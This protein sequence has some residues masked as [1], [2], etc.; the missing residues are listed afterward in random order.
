MTETMRII[1]LIMSMMMMRCRGCV[2][3]SSGLVF[4]V[5]VAGDD[6]HAW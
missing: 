1:S 3:K 4:G 6:M 2:E 5:A